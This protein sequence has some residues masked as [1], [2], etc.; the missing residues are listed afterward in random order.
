MIKGSKN[1]GPGLASTG[2]IGAGVENV[3]VVLP[4]TVTYANA[5]LLKPQILFGN[6]NKSGIYLPPPNRGGNEQIKKMVKPIS[7]VPLIYLRDY[8]TIIQKKIWRLNSKK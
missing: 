3:G 5:D 8:Q 2:L 1:V 4:L 7:E 6:K